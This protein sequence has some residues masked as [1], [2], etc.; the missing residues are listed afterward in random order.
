VQEN[1]NNTDQLIKLTNTFLDTQLNT[2]DLHDNCISRYA[3]LIYQLICTKKECHEVAQTL[4]TKTNSTL[5]NQI[6]KY[7]LPGDDLHN[8]KR[9][10]YRYLYAYIHHLQGTQAHKKGDLT[11]AEGYYRLASQYSPDEKDKQYLPAYD[12]DKVF[13]QGKESYTEDYLQFLAADPDKLKSLEALTKLAI[14]SPIHLSKLRSFYN[15]HFPHKESFNEYWE[16]ELNKNLKPATDFDLLQI[17]NRSFSLGQHTGKWVLMDFWGT[18]CAPCIEEMPSMQRFY[19]EAA[20][21]HADKLSIITIACKDT[22]TK[23]KTFMNKHTYNF[24]VGM[25]TPDMEE[26][27]AIT[28]YPT[29]LLITPKGNILPIASGKNWVEQVKLYVEL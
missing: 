16:A 28:A 29:K 20:T 19:R 3:L 4:L 17:N 18:W 14:E 27:Y 1:E 22:E 9:A 13:L 8:I 5:D 6:R 7:D 21:K 12:Y 11:K 26:K 25:A 24:P 10:W 15:G 2:A 23:V